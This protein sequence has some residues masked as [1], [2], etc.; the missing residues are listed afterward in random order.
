MGIRERRAQNNDKLPVKN[1]TGRET[2]N[3]GAPG[4]GRGMTRGASR[5]RGGFGASGDRGARGAARGGGRGRGMSRGG[6]RGESR[7][8]S[9]GGSRGA[10]RGGSRG[11]GFQSRNGTSLLQLPETIRNIFVASMSNV[12]HKFI[13]SENKRRHPWWWWWPRRKRRSRSWS[14]GTRWS[15]QFRGAIGERRAGGGGRGETNA[16]VETEENGGTGGA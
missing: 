11:G 10:S 13:N 2:S 7:G 3:R 6:S 14:W 8:A 9:R 12:E 4:R 5:G 15:T 16:P 1:S